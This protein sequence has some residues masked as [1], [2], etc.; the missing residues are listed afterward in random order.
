MNRFV[1]LLLPFGAALVL[2][3]CAGMGLEKA[4]NLT[5]EGSAFNMSLYKGYVGLAES[6][7]AEADYAD[8][9]VFAQRAIGAGSGQA[10]E[11]EQIDR[12]AL[13]EDKVAELTGARERLTSALS[14]GAAERK[15][16]EAAHA[17]VMFDCWMQEQEENIQP[18]DIARCRAALMAALDDLEVQPVAMTEPAPPGTSRGMPIPPRSRGF[19]P[20]AIPTGPAPTPTTTRSPDCA[21]MWSLST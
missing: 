13:P 5:P 18:E 6:E 19:S 20:A 3:G 8:S 7:Y 17:Q 2:S 14:A 9:D 1:K 11:P 16:A 21:S 15:P 12:R 10:V 4:H